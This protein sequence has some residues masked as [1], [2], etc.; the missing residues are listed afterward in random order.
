M[1]RAM[2]VHFGPVGQLVRQIAN[3]EITQDDY[4]LVSATL[5][6]LAAELDAIHEGGPPAVDLLLDMLGRLADANG[7][8]REV[9]LEVAG[10]LREMRE[11]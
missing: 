6:M 4:P 7:D 9:I 2:Q 1:M 8:I 3:E 11:D 10:T 5:G